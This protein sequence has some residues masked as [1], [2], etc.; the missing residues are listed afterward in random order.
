MTKSIRYTLVS[1]GVTDGN[2][3]P[4]INWSLKQTGG[5]E[6]AEGVRAEFWRLQNKPRDLKARLLSAIELFPCDILFVHR[7][8]E[9]EHA[10][11]RIEEIRRGFD[12][13]AIL[14]GG[15]PAVAIVP[16]RMLEAWLCFDHRAICQAAGNPNGQVALKLPALRR[17]E[18]RPDPKRELQ[19]ALVA[20]SELRGRRHKKFNTAAAFWRIVDFID[21]FSPLRQL[22][23]FRAFEDSVMKLK[24]QGWK[25]GFYG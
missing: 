22:S 19:D 4:I 10:D 16:I 6:I 25:P 13:A 14:V 20:A 21:D 15:V 12:A 3:I 24:S 5:V 9:T 1:D 2:L 8:A 18:S 11:V 23:A 7:D 17:I